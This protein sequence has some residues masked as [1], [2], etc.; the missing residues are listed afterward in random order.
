M[1][2]RVEEGG[3][4]GRSLHSAGRSNV[5]RDPEVE[6]ACL[7]E[8]QV[9]C[10]GVHCAAKQSILFHGKEFGLDLIL[11]VE[12]NKH[13]DDSGQQ[14]NLLMHAGAL[15]VELTATRCPSITRESISSLQRNLRQCL[16]MV[17]NILLTLSFLSLFPSRMLER[18]FLAAL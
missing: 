16:S 14:K 5:N 12:R 8:Q 10:A 1:C 4:G 11:I 13:S 2:A 17:F 7:G 15:F 6:E 18:K 9:S 3:K